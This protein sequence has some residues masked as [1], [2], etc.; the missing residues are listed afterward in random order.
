MNEA[1]VFAIKP[2]PGAWFADVGQIWF[3]NLNSIP[4]KSGHVFC[5]RKAAAGEDCRLAKQHE[6]EL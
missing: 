2:R 1:S 6:P 4:S 3:Q 5:S